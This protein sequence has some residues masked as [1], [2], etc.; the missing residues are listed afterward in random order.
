M[1]KTVSIF[2]GED[3]G[4]NSTLGQSWPMPRKYLLALTTPALL[5]ISSY[6]SARGYSY[7][8]GGGSS[9]SCGILCSLFRIGIFLAI[10]LLII[11]VITSTISSIVG[12]F[13]PE[14]RKPSSEPKPEFKAPL[15]NAPLCPK[16]NGPMRL[17]V[18]RKG[19]LSGGKFYGC[20]RFPSCKGTRSYSWQRPQQ[21]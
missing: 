1:K 21:P 14:K 17:R 9:G 2:S 20:A 4:V 18:A 12:L 6:A 16:C 8:G 13:N 15:P 3:Q 11:G 5:L 19:K 10:L 7:S